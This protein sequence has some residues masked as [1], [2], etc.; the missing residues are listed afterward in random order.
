[1]RRGLGRG[2]TLIAI[3]AVLATCSMPLAWLRVGGVVL[4]AKT[5]SGFEGAGVFMF[6]AA[7]GMLALVVSPYATRSR[8]FVLDRPLVYLALLLVGLAG[9]GSEALR[10]LAT[11]G[12][13]VA[14]SDAPGLWLAIA[15]M[16]VATWGVLECFAERPGAP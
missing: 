15:G 14:P 1:M 2:R 12:S 5:A 16:A 8:S 6:L 3:G 9:L 4:A 10:L 7:V 11:E 13:S